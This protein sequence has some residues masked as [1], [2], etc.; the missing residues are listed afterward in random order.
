MSDGG[1]LSWF[2]GMHIKWENDGSLL[3]GQQKY[4]EGVLR[5]FKMEKQKPRK[6]PLSNGITLTKAM[7]PQTEVEKEKMKSKPYRSIIGSLMYGMVATRPDLAH[8]VGVLSRFSANPG[9]EH[10]QA[11]MN[12]LGY[13]KHTSKHTLKFE[14]EGTLELTLYVDADFANDLDT[15]RSTSGILLWLQHLVWV[16]N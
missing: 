15:R 10:L 14:K 13:L 16:G 7:Q 11:A 6:F 5:K 12:T 8:S 4:F 2:L 3:L 1:P 9:E